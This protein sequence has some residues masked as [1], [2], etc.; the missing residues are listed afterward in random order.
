MS[1]E[2][3]VR[4]AE[5]WKYRSARI[6]AV[7]L[8]AG[9]L[10]AGAL[11]AAGAPMA[12]AAPPV[13]ERPD[14]TGGGQVVVPEPWANAPLPPLLSVTPGDERWMTPF[15]EPGIAGHVRAMAWY[16][17]SL[18]LGGNFN[19]AGGVAASAIV[20]YD[21]TGWHPMGEGLS[22]DHPFFDTPIVF[23]LQV[24]RGEL[25]VAGIFTRAGGVDA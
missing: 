4:H 2:P 21:A 18:I 16:E 23:D 22:I 20:R 5:S 1:F 7:V 6:H 13:V 19:S 8:L 10:T 12:G 15:N 17:G 9:F 25:Y 11:L 3:F 14:G 24:Y